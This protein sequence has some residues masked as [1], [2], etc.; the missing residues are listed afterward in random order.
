MYKIKY[1]FIFIL[2]FILSACQTTKYQTNVSVEQQWQNHKQVLAQINSFQVNGSI[3][4]I[5]TKTKSY[6]RF[7]IT[8]QSENYYDVKLTTPVGTNILTLKSEPNY[9]ELIDNNGVRYHDVNVELL[10]KKISNVNIP[11]NSLHNWLKG[12][13]DDSQADKIDSSGRLSSTSFMQNN[14]K[15]SLKI[16]SYATYTYKNKKIDLPAIIEL[17]H[18]DELIRL[19]ISNWI[20]R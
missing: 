2:P 15:W 20:L 12:F 3:A 13:S 14:N 5:E 6:G 8:Q 9:A 1:V 4:H 19:K 18:D 10:M 16:S 17:S 11:L 7:H